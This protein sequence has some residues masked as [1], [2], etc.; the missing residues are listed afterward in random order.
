M[1]GSRHCRV[2]TVKVILSIIAYISH[3]YQ[4]HLQFPTMPPLQLLALGVP[5]ANDHRTPG[6][7]SHRPHNAPYM[8]GHR[9][10]RKR[11]SPVSPVRLRYRLALASERP[12]RQPNYRQ[13]SDNCA[14][15]GR[16]RHGFRCAAAT[17]MQPHRHWWRP[18]R[19]MLLCR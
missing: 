17:G 14:H 7:H 15:T 11:T 1:K 12:V 13:R 16:L 9:P 6:I 8:C 2:K 10:Q 19:L 4:H 5:P 3:Y 18:H